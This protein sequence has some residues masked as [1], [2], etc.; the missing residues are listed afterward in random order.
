[1]AIITPGGGS[2]GLLDF[3]RSRRARQPSMSRSRN[4]PMALVISLFM[5]SSETALP[6]SDWAVIWA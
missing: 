4:R 1:V 2:F 3:A 6:I 5:L